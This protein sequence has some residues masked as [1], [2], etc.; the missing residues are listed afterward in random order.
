VPPID[1][2]TAI[3][4]ATVLCGVAIFSRKSA[5]K[6]WFAL[7]AILSLILLYDT[8]LLNTYLGS[9]LPPPLIGG[10]SPL[11]SLQY[12]FLSGALISGVIAFVELGRAKDSMS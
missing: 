6:S 9:H 4:I 11:E 12:A 2:A 5:G 10:V 3:G 1:S 7:S 8:F